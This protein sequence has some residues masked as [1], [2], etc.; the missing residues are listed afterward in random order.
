MKK[1]IFSLVVLSLL[2]QTPV[3]ATETEQEAMSATLTNQ[4]TGVPAETPRVS[5][6]QPAGMPTPGTGSTGTP[7]QNQMVLTNDGSVILFMGWR[8]MKYDAN[9][10][11]VKDVVIPFPKFQGRSKQPTP[12]AAEADQS[13]AARLQEKVI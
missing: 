1:I 12:T 2:I 11:L 10:N 13:A 3:F 8:L 4:S 9:L 6:S 7:M 5:M